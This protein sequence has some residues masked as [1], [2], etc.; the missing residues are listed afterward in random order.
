MQSNRRTFLAYLIPT[1]LAFV[2]GCR[3]IF[4]PEED[5]VFISSLAKSAADD[6]ILP[7]SVADF[8]R[9]R[10][11]NAGYS[12][13]TDWDFGAG[14]LYL[15]GLNQHGSGGYEYFIGGNKPQG[16]IN[17][18][19]FNRRHKLVIKRNGV[20]VWGWKPSVLPDVE[21]HRALAEEIN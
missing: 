10:G 5:E 17:V 8:L 19:S 1:L 15:T 13:Q 2:A 12:E 3:R 21:I 14:L 6:L 20:V 9:L 16:A 18:V 11:V 7:G 4:S